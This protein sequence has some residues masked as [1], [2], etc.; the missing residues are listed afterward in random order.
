M[1]EERSWI[2]YFLFIFLILI[3][4][5]IIHAVSQFKKKAELSGES[6]LS[7]TAKNILPASKTCKYC[8]FFT[9]IGMFITGII[10]LV[11]G[12]DGNWSLLQL[13][14]V[15]WMNLHLTLTVIFILFFGLHLY[16]HSHWLKNIFN[17]KHNYIRK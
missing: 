9:F 15:Q 7:I 8:S 13:S 11:E 3:T 16:I 2:M 6:E 14:E 5:I 4:A 1:I 17:R 10:L 12:T